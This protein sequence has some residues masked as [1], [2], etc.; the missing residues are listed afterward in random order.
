[1]L[2]VLCSNE[3][4]A[5]S[6][7]AYIGFFHPCECVCGINPQK[8]NRMLHFGTNLLSIRVLTRSPTHSK[9]MGGPVSPQPSS[10]QVLQI[11]LW[12]L[13]PFP[14]PRPHC[15]MFITQ[16]PCLAPHPGTL[17]PAQE[18]WVPPGHPHMQADSPTEAS[19]QSWN[20][21]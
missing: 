6:I 20:S 16:P 17:P 13:V 21:V 10:C 11:L 15:P 8:C 7:L 9:K 18:T 1:M 19:A 5:M 4:A 12:V 2:L 14:P 3:H